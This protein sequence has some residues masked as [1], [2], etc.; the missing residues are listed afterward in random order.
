MGNNRCN[1]TKK[2]SKKQFKSERDV[3]VTSKS[4]FETQVKYCTDIFNTGEKVIYLHCMGSSINRCLNLALHIIKNSG[5]RLLYSIH[6]STIQLIDET[7]PLHEN[8]DIAL[9][10]RFN[11]ALHIKLSRHLTE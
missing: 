3:Y 11:S 4:S 1:Q 10:T 9:R 2:V 5:Q 8:E 7:H 6:T